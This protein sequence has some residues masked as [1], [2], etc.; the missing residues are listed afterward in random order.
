MNKIILFLAAALV[1]LLVK[2]VMSQID[3]N[4]PVPVDPEVRIGVL[5]NGITY[6]IRH[7]EEPKERASF[8]IFQNVGALLEEDNQNG[9][10]HFLEHMAFN[11]TEHFEGKG[12]LHT[13]EKHG[14][15]FGRNINAYTAYNETVYNL[16]DVPTKDEALVDTCLLILHDWTDFLLLTDEEIDAERGVIT[17][18]WRTR[19]NS[20]YRLRDQYFPV[21]LKGSKWAVRDVIGDTTVIRYHKPETLKKF[22]HDWYRTDLQ[23]I[24]IV[25]D[26]DVD[27]VEASIQSIFSDVKPIENPKER[28]KFEIPEHEDTYFVLATDKEATQ[29]VINIYSLE[30][31]KDGE[32][33]TL[34]DYRNNYIQ[35]LF[36]TMIGNRI[37]ELL[38]KGT[39]PFVN[40]Y[41]Q[42]GGF[43]RGY[44]TTVIGT[45][46]NPNEEAKALEAI[47][48]EAYRAKLHGFTEGELERAK[49][50]LL[51]SIESGY[52]QRDKIRNDRFARDYKDHFLT[53]DAIPSMEFSFEFASKILPT[54]TVDEVSAKAQ[55]WVND[56]NRTI[57][58]TGPDKD[59]EHLT[60]AEA[61]EI[62]QKVENANIEAYVDE[63]TAQ[64]LISEELPGG[65]IVSTKPIEELSAVE[66]T[67]ENGAKVIFRK[68]DFE[69]DNV[70]IRSYSPGGKSLYNVAE[71]PSA[72]MLN[73][74]IGAYGVGDF[75]S[76]TLN[77][78]LAGKK[79]SVNPGIGELTE[80]INGS[81]TPKDFE[82]MMQ[83]L[84]LYFE[85]PR[86]DEEAHNALLARYKAYVMNVEKD[87]AKIQNDSLTNILTSYSPRNLDF[88][89]D[90]ISKVDFNTIKEIYSERYKD[91]SDFTFIIVGNIEEATVKAMVE[92][93]I[94]SLTDI[95]RKETWLDHPMN[96]PKGV[97]EKKIEIP[98]T[99]PK[100]NVN[101]VFESDM[102]YKRENELLM[103]VVK[104]LLRLNYTETVREKE[105]G[106]YG[107][108]V[109]GSVSELPSPETSLSINFD[110]DPDKAEHLKS[111]IYKELYNIV[112][113]GPN[114][115][116]FD[117]TIKN[118]LK[119]REQ[120]KEHNSYWMNS[121][122]NYYFYNI[123]TASDKAYED[124]L[125]NMT[126]KDV[127]K[128]LKKFIKGAD[129]VDVQFVPKQ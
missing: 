11:G 36:N 41:I 126:E 53:K 119:D 21:L 17:E 54:I 124:I 27:Q 63:A 67:L 15:A 103:S 116:D 99:T 42:H 39:P 10:A 84:Y 70:A 72:E 52:K 44:N 96:M 61:F 102:K 58:I 85:H 127:Q 86:F 62:L 92:K 22:Y 112:D 66:W 12:I 29:S 33:K 14:V 123:N 6:Y 49:I 113:N 5:D 106:T 107:V 128:Y 48:T 104:G 40:G 28:T 31:N 122:Y 83:L 51:T 1:M 121:I 19:R 97:T 91:A 117:K 24:A 2:P 129:R 98:F 4:Q 9:L 38:Q 35:T 108:R 37:Q 18:E 8:Y 105:G 7:N 87:P 69:K 46:A 75:S 109:G 65:K 59:V 34:G 88:N 125:K 26:V 47:Y 90:Y 20:G 76:I 74:F 60:E 25:G 94:G 100:T 80:G 115:V 23:G 114:S 77:K 89:S 101:V 93:Y 56:K 82:T 3:L 13:L 32:V 16:S 71:L 68:A 78:L 118:L 64:E 81:S 30:K 55:E 120:S 45:T 111:I 73:S 50:N 79:V 57:V 43:V 110:C 95:D